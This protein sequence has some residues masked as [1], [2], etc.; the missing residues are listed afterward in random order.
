VTTRRAVYAALAVTALVLIVGRWGAALYTDFLWFDALGAADVWRARIGTTVVIETASFLVATAY[1]CLNLYAV[2][3]SVVSLVLPR[4]IGNIEIGEEVP[5]RYL[6]YAVLFLS[7]VVGFA[8]VL[9]TEA[10]SEAL[11]ANIGQPF[12]EN[13]P[14]FGADL[15]FFVYWLPFETTLHLWAIVLFVAVAG[16]VVLLYAMTPSLGWED[17]RF[18]ITAYVRRHF[19]MLGGVLLLLVA[20]SYRLAMYRMLAEGGGTGGVFTPIDHRVLVP[21]LLV[22]GVITLCAALV[23]TWAGWSGQTRVAMLAVGTVLV[24]SIVGKSVAPLLARRAADPAAAAVQERAY[25][26]TRYGYTRRA[27]GVDRIRP[28][29]LGIGFPSALDAAARVGVWD[30]ATLAQAA[31]RLRRVH[32]VG[33]GAAWHATANGISAVLVEHTSEPSGDAQDVWGLRHFDPTASDERGMPIREGGAAV[34]E[35]LVPEP[36]VYDGAPEVSVLSDS[37]RQI[38][39]VELVSTRSRFAHAWSLQNFRLL[40][41]DFPLDRPTIVRHRDVRDR[42]DELVP[43]FVQGSAVTPLVADDTLYWIVELYSAADAYPLSQRF[44]ILGTERGYF[45]HAATALVHSLSG[46]VQLVAA[47]SPDPVAASWMTRFPGLFTTTGALSPAVRNALPPVQDGASTQALAFAAAGFRGDSLEERHFAISDGADSAA[48]REPMRVVLPGLDVNILWTL[49]DSRQRVRGVVA[50]SGGAQRAT[51]WIPLASDGVRWGAALDR[52]RSADSSVHEPGVVHAP[53]RVL[54]V[55]GQPFYLQSS[56]QWQPGGTPKL[57]R[58]TTLAGD[59]LRTGPTLRT[60]LGTGAL[61]Q[62]S[63]PVP[64]NDLRTRA[65]SLYRAMRDALGHSDWSTFGRSFDSL[66]VLLRRPP[67]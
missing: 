25:L 43:F 7:A 58:V 54:P 49:L 21:A 24:L 28:E 57:V 53:V 29:S 22:L 45:Q 56:F 14:Y 4:R 8:C 42:L 63:P 26:A 30:G 37:L 46:R 16:L 32:I 65:E 2:R 60:A 1:A 18:R 36:S 33:D 51:S 52:M 5:S 38:A 19:I 62:S 39:G 17:G 48:S 27:Y 11:L 40:F 12:G 23:V 47:V 55:A 20:W 67:P 15:G 10:W 59:T 64:A 34:E 3:R 41:G 31:Q 66:G 13:D 61:T 50:A 9:P 35:T 44:S 6:F